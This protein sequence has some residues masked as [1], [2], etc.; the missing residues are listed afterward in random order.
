MAI[1]KRFQSNNV[2]A[3]HELPPMNYPKALTA[4]FIDKKAYFVI[5]LI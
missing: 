4:I 2:H 5:L 3:K 1:K